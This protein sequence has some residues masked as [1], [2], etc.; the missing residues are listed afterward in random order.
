MKERD[1]HEEDG[2]AWGHEMFE[3]RRQQK[4]LWEAAQKLRWRHVQTLKPQRKP[5]RQLAPA[6]GKDAS[7]VLP[8]SANRF[9]LLPV[10]RRHVFREVDAGEHGF[11]VRSYKRAFF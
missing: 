11:E 1:P 5:K 4:W 7:I 2:I 8:V 6:R 9:S 10:E 3:H